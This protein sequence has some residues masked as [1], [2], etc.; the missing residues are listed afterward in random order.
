MEDQRSN[1]ERLLSFFTAR[2]FA[3]IPDNRFVR[4]FKAS[5]VEIKVCLDLRTY[6]LVGLRVISRTKVGQCFFFGLT[7]N[8]KG[9]TCRPQCSTQF[10][11]GGLKNHAE[12]E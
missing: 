2:V 8:A 7:F 3:T 5:F 6:Q 10:V 11:N 12:F 1:R 9:T 4:F